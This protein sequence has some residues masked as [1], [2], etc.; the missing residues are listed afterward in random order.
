MKR[1]DARSASQGFLTDSHPVSTEPFPKQNIHDWVTLRETTSSPVRGRTLTETTHPGQSPW[2]PFAQVILPQEVL[3]RN[4]QQEEFGERSKG[5]TTC[6]ATSQ[7]PSHWHPS[8][9]SNACATR[10]CPE[11][12][13]LA[14]DSL[15][16]NRITMK[17]ETVS[18]LAEQFSWVPL[19][20]PSKVSSFVSMCVSSHN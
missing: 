18:Q 1:T 3:V 17:P 2:Q 6:P 15:E 4:H 11:S 5:G 9:L 10:K 19:P 8:W 7:N 12:E 14:R 16:T 13:R 20:L